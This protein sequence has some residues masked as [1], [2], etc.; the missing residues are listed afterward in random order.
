VVNTNDLAEGRGRISSDVR[1]YYVIGYEPDPDTFAPERRLARRHAI[2]V[3]VKRTGVRVRARKAFIGV[4][5]AERPSAPQTPPEALVRAAMS[6]FGA[7]T[8]GLHA[9]NLPGY[10]RERGMFVRTVLHLDAHALTFTAD[11][12][13][14]RTA[15]VDLAGLVFDSDGAKVHSISTGFNVTLEDRAAEQAI[16]DGLVYTARVPIARP[17]GY[18]LRF[19]VRDRHS[20]AIGA[21]GGFALVP[22]V[23]GG[24]FALSG[25]LLQ[26]DRRTAPSE[27]LDSDRFS[28]PPADALRVYKPGTPLS[29]WYE[30]YNAHA[31][32]TV[33]ATLWRGED[34]LASLPPDTL[35]PLP[36]GR[37]LSAR[38]RLRLA[39]DLPA[40]TYVLQIAATSDDPKHAKRA[41]ATVQRL[42]FDIK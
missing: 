19:A 26:A 16:R 8:L 31:A 20:G 25:L 17:G 28:V 9:T 34:S 22:D 37:P 41:R 36:D 11:A 14:T 32:V 23:T 39:D 29:Y 4:S 30:I 15:T 35:V 24:A 21:V 13:G 42:S 3:K 7:A 2:T 1:D 40:G 6:P 33:A 10:S 18:N 38:G 5:D 12:A 27:L